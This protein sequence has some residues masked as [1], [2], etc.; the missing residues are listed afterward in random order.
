MLTPAKLQAGLLVSN[1]VALIFDLR[2][3]ADREYSVILHSLGTQTLNKDMMFGRKS[4]ACLYKT[5]SS[6]CFSGRI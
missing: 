1:K 3:E 5:L 6:S 4:T 2:D